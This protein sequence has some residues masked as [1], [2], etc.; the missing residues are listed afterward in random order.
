MWTGW[1]GQE[2]AEGLERWVAWP[3]RPRQDQAGPS[4]DPGSPRSAGPGSPAPGGSFLW[5]PWPWPWPCP[6]G[7]A[8]PHCPYKP[9]CASGAPSGAPSASS[10]CYLVLL[11][12]LPPP[13]PHPPPP[14]PELEAAVVQ[15]QCPLGLLCPLGLPGLWHP[16]PPA[17][18]GSHKP[19]LSLLAPQTQSERGAEAR[20]GAA[21]RG[22]WG[23]GLALHP[24]CAPGPRAR[25][26]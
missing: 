21:G 25:L 15:P 9:A 17:P 18:R 20:V 14:W 1:R 23:P 4:H 26:R 8:D 24:P 11:P 6:L 22:S 3:W 7:A 13:T 12:L 5:G 19:D 10:C 2:L 16:G